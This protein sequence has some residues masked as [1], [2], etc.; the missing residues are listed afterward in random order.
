[1]Q[2]QIIDLRENQI[3]SMKKVYDYIGKFLQFTTIL[4]WDNKLRTLNTDTLLNN[5]P[6]YDKRMLSLIKLKGY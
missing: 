3:T 1:M 5:E 2:L 4:A 6:V